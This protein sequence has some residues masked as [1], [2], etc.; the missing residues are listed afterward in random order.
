MMSDETAGAEVK[1]DATA[2]ETSAAP[3]DAPQPEVDPAEA[4]RAEN[5]DLRDKLLRAVAEMDNLRKRTEREVNDTRS[6]AIASF[7]R[8]MLTATDSLSRA[9]MVLPAEARASA[10]ASMTSLIEGIEMTEREMQRLLAKHGVKQIE[11]EGQKFDPHKHQAMFEVPDPTRPEGTVVQVVQ[12]GFA[13][14]DRVLRPAMVG[15]AKGAPAAAEHAAEGGV[16]KE[17]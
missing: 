11:A 10:D 14:G 17:A 9:L 7:A 3:A 13:I 4:L 5:A 16:D 1:P 2:P 8:D 12:A 6:Y 15:I